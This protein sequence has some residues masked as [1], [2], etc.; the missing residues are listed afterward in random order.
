[1]QIGLRGTDSPGTIDHPLVIADTLLCGAVVVRVARIAEPLGAIEF[2]PTGGFRPQAG[3]IMD[4]RHCA[5][6]SASPL[7]GAGQSRASHFLATT[8]LQPPPTDSQNHGSLE[9][10]GLYIQY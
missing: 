6:A 8:F 2:R 5:L 3:S 1:M 7:T 4:G 9:P 10:F